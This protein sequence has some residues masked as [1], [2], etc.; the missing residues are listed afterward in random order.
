MNQAAYRP[1]GSLVQ[2]R[3]RA[4]PALTIEKGIP[5]P[6]PK[7]RR[8]EL[9]ETLAKMVVGDSIILPHDAHVYDIAKSIGIRVVS[10]KIE[11]GGFRVWR[12]A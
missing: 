7:Q 10:S 2:L 3:E 9:R 11:A 8:G 5:M 1:T 6:K 4:L 12:C